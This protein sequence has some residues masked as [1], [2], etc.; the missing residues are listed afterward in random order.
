MKQIAHEC[1]DE[2]GR[3]ISCHSYEDG[4]LY[5]GIEEY[6]VQV[7]FCP[8]CGFQPDR[9]KREDLC[10][11]NGR[12]SKACFAYGCN[13]P[14]WVREYQVF[15][16]E[17][18]LFCAPCWQRV[19]AFVD[20]MVNKHKNSS[21]SFREECVEEAAKMIISKPNSKC[22]MR[23]SEHCGNTVREVQ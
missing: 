21:H 11:E 4:T 17:K 1:K 23:C 2:S 6:E 13:Q 12:I 8:F 10:K 20:A 9:S 14:I 7:A 22:E 19:Y 15:D 5:M 3:L 16:I 18:P